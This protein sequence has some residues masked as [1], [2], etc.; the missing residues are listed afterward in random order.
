[1]L[2]SELRFTALKPTAKLEKTAVL[3]VVL[4]E[5]A[6]ATSPTQLVPLVHSVPVLSQVVCANEVRGSKTIEQVVAAT[7]RITTSARNRAA[8]AWT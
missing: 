3:V 4:E 6:G 5:F 7:A 8:E 1:M 2:R